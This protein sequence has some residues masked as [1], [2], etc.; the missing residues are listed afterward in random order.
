MNPGELARMAGRNF[1]AIGL[2]LALA[3]APTMIAA[4]PV[5]AAS[6]SPVVVESPVAPVAAVATAKTAASADKA[7]TAAVAPG[8]YVPMKPTAGK[9]MPVARGM[10]VQDQF[11][12]VGQQARPFHVALLYLCAAIAVFVLGLLLFVMIRFNKRAN[13]VP[14]KTSHNTVLE[15]VWTVIPIVILMVVFV[16]SMKL[17]GSQYAEVPANT[18]TIKVTGNQWFWTYGYPDN[19]GFEVVSNMLPDAEAEK[20]GEPACGPCG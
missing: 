12:P 8:K 9:G 18:L 15:I 11:S 7:G 10:D 16:P 4:Q 2:T 5:P 20:R 14:S 19:G 6:P 1:K 3:L 13:P 17:L